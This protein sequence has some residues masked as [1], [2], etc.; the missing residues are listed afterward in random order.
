[1]LESGEVDNI[2]DAIGEFPATSIS[3]SLDRA[4]IKAESASGVFVRELLGNCRCI[5]PPFSVGGAN[6][7][8]STA[9]EFDA[10][11]D[12]TMPELSPFATDASSG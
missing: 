9:S 4:S 6:R 7:G 2:V 12:V 3:R 10:E 11:G 1:M 8:V 5:S